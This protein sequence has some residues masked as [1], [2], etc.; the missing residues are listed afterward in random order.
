M[1]TRDQSGLTDG[2]ADRDR[3]PGL[4]SRRATLADA[5]LLAGMNQQL[6]E[7]EVSPNP[8]T[9]AELTARMQEFLSG[10]HAAVLFE[11]A[12]EPV[13]YALF[14]ADGESIALHQFFVRREHPRAELGRAA[15]TMLI[16]DYFPP[17]ARLTVEVTTPNEAALRFWESVGFRQHAI[18]LERHLAPDPPG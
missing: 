16:D 12:G 11:L 5:A 9:L 10:A 18:T 3:W 7:D 6:I 4:T 17:G 15:L 2:P 14:R 8:L 1:T 13:A